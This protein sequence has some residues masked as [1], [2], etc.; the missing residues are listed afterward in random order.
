MSLSCLR[1]VLCLFL[2]FVLVVPG[3]LLARGRLSRPCLV[4]LARCALRPG[5]VASLPLACARALV[6]GG[7]G[8]R[9]AR[10]LARWCVWGFVP[11]P[12][13]APLPL[14]LGRGLVWRAWCA[15]GPRAGLWSGLCRF[16]LRGRASASGRLSFCVCRRFARGRPRG[17]ARATGLGAGASLWRSSSLAWRRLHAFGWVLRRRG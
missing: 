7:C 13:P 12:L 17:L 6:G 3:R 9:P 2:S 10:S 5:G 15:C 8:V 1:G 4:F 16:L 11:R 14:G